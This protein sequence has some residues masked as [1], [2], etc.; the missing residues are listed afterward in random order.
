MAAGACAAVRE[1]AERLGIRRVYPYVTA[2]A[3]A[4]RRNGG[5]PMPF[6]GIAELWLDDL[7]AFRRPR[8]EKARRAARELLEDERRCIDL[9]ASPMW[10]DAERD[11]LATS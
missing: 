6:D 10:L 5:A 1:R 11:V 2:D 3:E 9:A 7:E 4:L 8:R